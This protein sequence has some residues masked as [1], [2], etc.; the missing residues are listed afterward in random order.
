MSNKWWVEIAE[1]DFVL[2]EDV[3]RVYKDLNTD[4]LDMDDFVYYIKFR[5]GTKEVL[6]K[7]WFLKVVECLGCKD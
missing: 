1:D 7:E 2:R 4:S 5:D 6:S 3:V